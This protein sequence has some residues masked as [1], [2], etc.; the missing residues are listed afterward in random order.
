MYDKTDPVVLYTVSWIKFDVRHKMN[1]ILLMHF[2]LLQCLF[3]YLQNNVVLDVELID[4]RI[5]T[6]L[7]SKPLIQT[8]FRMRTL[9]LRPTLLIQEHN[10]H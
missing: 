8:F 4:S 1:K 7:R 10:G 2:P 9:H 3:Q 6:L 5:G